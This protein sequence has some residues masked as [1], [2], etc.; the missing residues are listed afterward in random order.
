MVKMGDETTAPEDRYAAAERLKADGK[1]EEA[2]TALEAIAADH[3]D[4]TLAFSAMSAWCT[5]LER[6][7]DAWELCCRGCALAGNAC[8]V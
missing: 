2:V 4:F 5:R 1:L 8:W 7:A 6:H 3:P